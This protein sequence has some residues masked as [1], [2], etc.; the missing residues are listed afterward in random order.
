LPISFAILKTGYRD[1]ERERERERERQTDRQTD[2]CSVRIISM[3]DYIPS[4]TLPQA[5]KTCILVTYSLYGEGT[6]SISTTA[7]AN[8]RPQ[9]T[10]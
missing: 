9:N 3:E 10:S 5:G 1:T 7:W 6:H 2:I 4:Y 8:K